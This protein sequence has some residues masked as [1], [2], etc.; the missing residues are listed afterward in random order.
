MPALHRLQCMSVWVM[1]QA[2]E[3][4]YE[5]VE[6]ACLLRFSLEAIS[7]PG[8]LLHRTLKRLQHDTKQYLIQ[9]SVYALLSRA[10][11]QVA[12]AD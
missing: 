2:I 7:W 9:D 4:L 12:V 3:R 5:L 1:L 10:A 6:H 8:S 11:G